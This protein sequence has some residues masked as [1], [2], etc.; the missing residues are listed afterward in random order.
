MHIKFM[1]TFGNWLIVVIMYVLCVAFSAKDMKEKLSMLRFYSD[2][3][4]PTSK[5]TKVASSSA[6]KEAK[7]PKLTADIV[8]GWSKSFDTLLADKCMSL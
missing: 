2:S 8:V 4:P 7:P 5:E 1:N 6:A 3:A